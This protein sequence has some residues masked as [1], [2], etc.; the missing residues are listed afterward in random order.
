[1]QSTE[2][3]AKDE[4]EKKVKWFKENWMVE[5]ANQKP[6]NLSH[7]INNEYKMKERRNAWIEQPKRKVNEKE[8]SSDQSKERSKLK[9]HSLT[10]SII[11]IFKMFSI[12]NHLRKLHA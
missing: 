11:I 5:K 1:M 8:T 9:R 2:T 4:F 12:A 10:V 7:E 6:Q 3:R